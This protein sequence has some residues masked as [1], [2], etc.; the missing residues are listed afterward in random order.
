MRAHGFAHNANQVLVACVLW[1]PVAS[2]IELLG[3]S[4]KSVPLPCLR[5]RCGLPWTPNVSQPESVGLSCALVTPTA[6]DLGITRIYVQR[7]R[8]YKKTN[9]WSTVVDYARPRS[10]MIDHGRTW[11]TMVDQGR[12]W[13]TIV[14]FGRPWSTMADHGRPCSAMVD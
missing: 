6:F 7:P 5:C 3:P 1:L 12:P 2:A 10:S 13:S 9:P 14:D 8:L 11:S 4:S